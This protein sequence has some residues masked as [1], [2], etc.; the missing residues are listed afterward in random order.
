[1]EKLKKFIEDA[2]DFSVTVNV[3]E[4]MYGSFQ[5]IDENGKCYSPKDDKGLRVDNSE[6]L[7]DDSYGFSGEGEWDKNEDVYIGSILI[8]EQSIIY[9]KDEFLEYLE[10][11]DPDDF[12]DIEDNWS[13]DEITDFIEETTLTMIEEG[14]IEG[15]EN[16]NL[17]GEADCDEFRGCGSRE[18]EI[19]DY[20]FHEQSTYDFDILTNWQDG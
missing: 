15:Y 3:S 14:V 5:V 20:V 13:K 19:C 9:S 18:Y 2:K 12:D 4:E 7:Y 6:Y 17:W 10:E 11:C 16:K 1:M 8:P